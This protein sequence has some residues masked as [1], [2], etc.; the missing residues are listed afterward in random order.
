M[1]F[2]EHQIPANSLEARLDAKH[3]DA[4]RELLER[5]LGNQPVDRDR[6]LQ[7]LTILIMDLDR[8]DHT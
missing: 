5:L 2:F 1:K 7:A 8:A 3:V 6:V 4:A